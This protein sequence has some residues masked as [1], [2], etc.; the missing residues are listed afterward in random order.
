M[1]DVT[2]ECQVLTSI[3]LAFNRAAT[4]IGALLIYVSALLITRHL[5]GTVARAIAECLILDV[6]LHETWLATARERSVRGTGKQTL[7]ANGF[8]ATYGSCSAG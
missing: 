8:I 4:G 2:V 7:L 5:A 6:L 1:I 3:L